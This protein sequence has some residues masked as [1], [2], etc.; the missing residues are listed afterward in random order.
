MKEQYYGLILAKRDNI[1]FFFKTARRFFV[2]SQL[3]SSTVQPEH[4][5]CKSKVLGI[6]WDFKE[7]PNRLN[8]PGTNSP[9][10]ARSILEGFCLKQVQ[11]ADEQ[12]NG[13]WGC[14]AQGSLWPHE[15]RGQRH[16]IAKNTE[17]KGSLL[18]APSS[19]HAPHKAPAGE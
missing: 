16:D 12:G 7:M 5:L 13:S 19:I 6:T 4:L 3:S 8:L 17:A 11:S 2:Y 1:F 14:P 15:E 10:K 9:Q 18:S